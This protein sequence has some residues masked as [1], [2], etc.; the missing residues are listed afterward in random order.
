[1]RSFMNNLGNIFVK[2][3][4]RSPLHFLLSGSIMLVTF[5]GRKSGKVY[6]TPVQYFRDGDTIIFFTKTVRT[7][8]K[9]LAG[10]RPV[11]LRAISSIRRQ[12][13]RGFGTC[14]RTWLPAA[15]TKWP[16]SR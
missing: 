4:L 3:L 7:W 13:R 11:T 15:S 10:E 14:T 6:T 12:S 16:A 5:T 9:N 1:M 2:P 8:W